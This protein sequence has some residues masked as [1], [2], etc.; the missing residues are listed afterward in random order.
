LLFFHTMFCSSSLYIIISHGML[1]VT[2]LPIPVP[3]FC[4]RCVPPQHWYP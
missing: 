1:K 3:C 4:L 2:S